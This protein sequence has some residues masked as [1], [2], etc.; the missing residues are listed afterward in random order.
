MDFMTAYLYGSQDSDIYMKVPDGISVPNTNVV[1]NM[2]YVKLNKSLYDLKQSGRMW[3][4]RL[5]EFLLNEGYSNNDDYPCVFIHKSS[6][7]FC[8]I[9]IYVDD[10]NIIDTE[11][12]INEA[13]DHLKTEF[14][15]KDLGKTK[16]CLGLQLE[17]LPTGTL[18]YQLAYVQKV[19]EKFNIDKTY[20]S[21]TLMVVRDLE[22]DT[23]LFQ[24]RQD[25][26]E[27]LGSKYPYL[28]A[29]VAIMYLTNNIRPDIAF[30]V[31][32]LARYSAAPT[33]RH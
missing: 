9:S 16:F 5:K 28:N 29:I 33:M 21:K 24:P 23:D 8:I 4:N 20:P 11:L 2:Y 15:M 19:L 25:G 18:I 12:E 22:K 26:E 32:L 17:H 30:T 10:L 31:N 7:G 13:R 6:T 1:H 27:V 14:K 3:Y